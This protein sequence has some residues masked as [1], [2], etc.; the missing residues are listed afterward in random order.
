MVWVLSE[1]NCFAMWV[2]SEKNSG[3]LERLGSYGKHQGLWREG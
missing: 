1:K 2:M 3:V